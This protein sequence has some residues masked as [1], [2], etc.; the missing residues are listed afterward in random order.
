MMS[1]SSS[2]RRSPTSGLPVVGPGVGRTQPRVGREV[3]E[4]ATHRV[5]GV[6]LARHGELR[7]PADVALHGRPAELLGADVLAQRG[8]HQRWPGGEDRAGP[9]DHD[10]EV[11]HRRGERAV[12]GRR[13]H[14]HRHGGHEAGEVGQRREV[15]RDRHVALQHLADAGTGAL[16][17]TD[18]RRALVAGEAGDPLALGHPGEADRTALHREVLGADAHRVT[19]DGRPAAH[20]AVGGDGPVRLGDPRQRGDLGERAG[21]AQGRNAGTDVVTPAITLAADPFVA[22]HRRGE[23]ALALESPEERRPL[24]LVL[25]RSPPVSH[26]TPVPRRGPGPP[27][28]SGRRRRRCGPTACPTRSSGR[29]RRRRTRSGRTPI[30]APAGGERGW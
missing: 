28:G 23:G 9:A 3:R 7:H 19:V 30:P 4:V 15:G 21:V 5:E 8:L 13:T 12:A 25:R 18:E 14:H 24:A 16:E 1:S 29:R 6:V 22:S 10:H 17:E 2:T 20:E 11:G 26:S 27:G